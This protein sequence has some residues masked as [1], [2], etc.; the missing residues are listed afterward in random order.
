MNDTLAEKLFEIARDLGRAE[1]SVKAVAE[2]L[3]KDQREQDR[4][5]VPAQFHDFIASNFETEA[6]RQAR[7]EA[8]RA[9]GQPMPADRGELVELY[10]LIRKGWETYARLKGLDVHRKQWLSQTLKK[11]GF[12]PCRRN[13][14]TAYKGLRFREG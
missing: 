14:Q 6:L 1:R 12:V 4:A 2:L 8:A 9:G 11:L 10:S 5:G 13:K 7:R 3:A